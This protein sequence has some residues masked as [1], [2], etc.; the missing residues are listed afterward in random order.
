MPRNEKLFNFRLG[1]SAAALLLGCVDVD[2]YQLRNDAYPTGGAPQYLPITG[3]LSFM[4]TGGRTAIGGSSS[5]GGTQ[6]D[7]WLQQ[8]RRDSVNRWKRCS[9][10]AVRRGCL[11]YLRKRIDAERVRRFAR[12]PIHKGGGVQHP[13][14]GQLFEHE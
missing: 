11:Q 13:L 12:L 9:G 4:L 5:Q 10:L 7:R 2:G 6:F 8:P 1:C 14:H 3:G